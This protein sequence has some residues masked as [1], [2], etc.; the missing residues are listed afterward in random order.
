MIV[1]YKA[2][3]TLIRLIE[4]LILIRIIISFLNIRLDNIFGEIIA[5][6]TEPVLA[7]ARNL[8]QKLNINTGLFDF[9]P[10]VAILLLRIFYD[11]V[12]RILFF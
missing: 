6:M 8:I 10:I 11:I 1:F 9:S 12:G 3:G 5:T 4:F 7:P 2:L